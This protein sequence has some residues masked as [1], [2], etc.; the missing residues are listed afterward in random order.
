[1]RIEYLWRDGEEVRHLMRAW[2]RAATVEAIAEIMEDY[3]GRVQSGYLP[4]GYAKAPMPFCARITRGGRVLA[5]WKPRT[6][7]VV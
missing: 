7:A 5:E 3:S 6:A 4:A 1:M 2:K